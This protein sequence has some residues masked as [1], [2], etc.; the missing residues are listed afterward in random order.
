MMILADPDTIGIVAIL[1]VFGVPII[2]ILSAFSH[3][4]DRLKAETELKRRMLERGMSAEE[5]ALVIAARPQNSSQRNGQR[6]RGYCARCGSDMNGVQG[7]C[8]ECGVVAQR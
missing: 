4:R 6:T 3:K 1:A 7:P 8:P 2:A 5:I